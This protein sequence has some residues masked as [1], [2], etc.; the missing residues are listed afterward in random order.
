MSFIRIVF[1]A[2]FSWRLASLAICLMA[3]VFTQPAAAGNGVGIRYG[4]ADVPDEVFE[5]SGDLGGTSLVGIHLRLAPLPL[6]N[7]EFAGEYTNSEFSFNEGLFDGIEAAGD[8]EYEDMTLLASLRMNIFTLMLLPID[9]YV[10]GGLNV[11]WTEIK[12]SETPTVIAK[13]KTLAD[14]LEDA[15]KDIAGENSE[16]GWHLLGGAELA[17]P[18]SGFSIFVEGRHMDAMDSSA[19]ASNSIYGGFSIEL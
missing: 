6:L 15:V 8:G 11:H 12:F 7:I 14:E 16:A 2:L 3:L 13:N 4:W 17:I 18:G 5:G 9:L 10:G 19:P 1:E